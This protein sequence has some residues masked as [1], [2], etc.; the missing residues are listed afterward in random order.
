MITVVIID[1]EKKSREVLKLLIQE[2]NIDIIILGEADSVETGFELINIK[3]PKLV[4][5][6]VEMLDG[7]GFNLLEKFIKIEFKIIFTTA[8]DEYAIKAFKYSVIDYLLKPIDIDEI[9]SAVLRTMNSLDEKT[10]NNNQIKVLL[11]N[12]KE[13]NTNKKIAI[14]S[15]S[16]IE[17]IYIGDIIYCQAESSYTYIVL[18]NNKKIL[19]TRTLK[20]YQEL[21]STKLFF[22]INKSQLINTNY[23]KEYRRV[24]TTIIMKNDEKMEVSRRKK[25]EFLIFIESMK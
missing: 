12:V 2:S 7:T 1:D 23:M 24:T 6:D 20:E 21:L 5:L 9:E 3:L 14:K 4:F 17:F 18:K 10:H 13:E 22:R 19:S 8:Y 25:K 15:A 11:D 16:K